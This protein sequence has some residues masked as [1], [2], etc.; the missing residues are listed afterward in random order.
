[1]TDPGKKF[2]VYKS[3]A[4]SGKTF[5]LVREYLKIV[6][7][8]PESFR[9]VL[10]I[11]FTN[12]AANEMK[13]R[14]VRNLVILSD[15]EKHADSD[16]CKYMLPELSKQLKISNELI[17]SRAA[18]VLSLIMHHYAEFAIST[19]DSFT[20]RVIRTFAH[21]LK[22]PMNFEVELDADSMLS[23][24]VDI[25]IS[26]VGSDEM[27]TKVMVDFVEKKAGDE[28]NWQIEKD[29]NDFGR[30]LLSESS[31]EAIN[32]IRNHDLDA[33][34][35]VRQSLMQWKITWEKKLTMLASAVTTLFNREG[36]TA[37]DFIYKD[38]GIFRESW[39]TIKKHK[40]HATQKKLF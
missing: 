18:I 5:T 26:Q 2:I 11:T 10:A 20:H 38:K 32:E 4:G 37:D 17:K 21:D 34:M 1:M 29:L 24:A 16:T 14:V 9:Q 27:L 7:Q 23:Q 36:L 39:G 15:P 30:T 6:L 35:K 13:D 22:I 31:L 40:S 8:N 28:L 3:S 33:F 19:I 25:L 12:K